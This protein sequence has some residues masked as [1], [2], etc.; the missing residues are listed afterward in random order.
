MIHQAIDILGPYEGKI[1]SLGLLLRDYL[2]TELN[3]INETVDVPANMLGYGYG[4]GYK[5]MVCTIIPSKK[6]IKLGF[7]R[8]SELPDPAGLLTG[9]G[10]LHKYVEIKSVEDI[11]QPA[12]KN[13]LQ[14][15][16]KAC[17][18]RLEKP[19]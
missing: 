19:A 6:G 8:G 16:G 5:G 13:L 3:G 17:Y 7:N 18:K 10:K 4:P 14:E 9:S 2:F 12:L 1:S 15:A 11:R